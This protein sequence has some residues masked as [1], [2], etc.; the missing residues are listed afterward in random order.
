MSTE[1][2]LSDTTKMTW[3]ISSWMI[4]MKEVNNELRI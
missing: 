1:E 3:N 4:T 2:R